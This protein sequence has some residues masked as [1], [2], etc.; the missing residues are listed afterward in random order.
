MDFKGRHE[1]RYNKSH[2]IIY[3]SGRAGRN[4]LNAQFQ[5]CKDARLYAPQGVEKEFG[6]NRPNDL[7]VNCTVYRALDIDLKPYLYLY[8]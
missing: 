3:L 5:H 6:M 7:G 4:M 2:V 1:E 8:L